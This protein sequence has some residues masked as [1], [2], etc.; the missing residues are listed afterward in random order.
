MA[1]QS[2][3]ADM[4]DDSVSLTSTAAEPYTS[5]QEFEVERILAETERGPKRYL[6]LWAGYPEERSTWEPKRHIQDPAILE[7]WGDHKMRQERGLMEPF[8]VKAWNAKLERLA[9]E[10]AE[11]HRRRR[12]KRRRLGLAVSSL[13]ELQAFDNSESS[14]KA[15]EVDEVLE[16]DSPRRRSSM[17]QP[18]TPKPMV[19]TRVNPS[20]ATI[21]AED[22]EFDGIPLLSKSETLSKTLPK[23]A[24]KTSAE[25]LKSK[26]SNQPISGSNTGKA[27]IFGQHSE[28]DNVPPSWGANEEQSKPSQ[29][30]GSGDSVVC[31]L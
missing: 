20:E 10:T 23:T 11:R 13:K 8:D 27:P 18:K 30:M 2:Y 28:S 25:P 15:I 3:E 31:I 1:T 5:D 12:D 17:S 14:D 19:K 16:D 4:D 22:N 9:R 21:F 26:K 24:A 29:A 6:I 7:V